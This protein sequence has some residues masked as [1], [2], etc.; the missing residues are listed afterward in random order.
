MEPN[1]NAEIKYTL[2]FINN[3]WKHSA[4]GKTFD[5]INPA[6]EDVICQV[7]EGD[8]EDVNQAVKAAKE[9]FALNSEWRSMDASARGKL[10][11]KLADLVERDCSYLASL[12]VLDNGK[13]FTF[14]YYVDMKHSI[15]MIRYCAGWADKICGKTIPTDGKY[16][17]YTKVEPLGVVGAITPWNFPLMMTV[18]KM[19]PALAAGNTVVL[20]PPEQTPLTTL[21][22]AALVKEAGFPA[23][24]FNVICGFGPTAGAGISEHPDI[25]KV[26]FTGSTEVGKIIQQASGRTNLKGVQVE[27]GGKSPNIVFADCDMDVAVEA[28]HNAVFF[29]MGQC[30][31]AGTR[32]FVQEEIYDEFVERSVE[33][34]KKRVIGNPWVAGVES[35]PQIDQD[36]YDKILELIG[37]GIQEGAKLLCGGKACGGDLAKGYYIE[38]TVFADVQDD[39]R[40]AKEEIFGPVM[41]ILKFKTIDEVITRANAT[42]YGLASSVFTKDLEKATY[43]SGALQ[44]GSVYVNCYGAVPVQA[45]FGGYKMSGFGR[46]MGE[47]GMMEYCQVKSVHVAIKNKNS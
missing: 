3:E 35:G 19:A 31:L 4:S 29:N 5:V 23:G 6:T 8:K 13:P 45:P 40:I 10:L 18:H 34:A 12:E 7:A 44:A 41:Q 38:S 28:S 26:S 16:F 17:S 36:Q 43:V 30:C 47:E 22:L 14:A 20:K 24:V 15:D 33:R 37:S 21:A 32:C 1:E 9:A 27:L 11:L 46:E 25:A 42:E 2:N 39:M